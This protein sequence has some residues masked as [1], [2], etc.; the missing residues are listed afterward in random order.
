[1]KKEMRKKV[2][3]E[4]TDKEFYIIAKQAHEADLTFNDYCNKILIDFLKLHE[5]DNSKR[6]KMDRRKKKEKNIIKSEEI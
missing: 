5:F 1:M 6:I 2:D 3:V 4:L